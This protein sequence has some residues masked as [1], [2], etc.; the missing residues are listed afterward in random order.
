MP[1]A[2]RDYC[3]AVADANG[4]P[5]PT[6]LERSLV[7]ALRASG[8]VTAQW[9][10]VTGSVDAPLFL[11]LAADSP[12][13]RCPQCARVHL[14]ASA[15]ACTNPLCKSTGLVQSHRETDNEDY[16]AWLAGRPARRLRVEELTGQ[17]KPLPEQRRRQRQFKGA[18]LQP[19]AEH[20]LTHA[21]DILSV[22]TTMEVGIDIGSLQSVMMANMPPQRF[23]YQQRVGRAGRLGQPF[24]FA[25]TLCRD[26]THD[27]YYF[28][29]PDHITSDPPAPPYLDLGRAQIIQRV[30]AAEALRLA[31]LSLAAP[32]RPT[33]GPDS[34]HG[35]FGLAVDWP[36]RY[37]GSIVDWLTNSAEISEIVTRLTSCTPLTPA[38]QDDLV[39]WVREGLVPAIDA[40]IA[41]SS[42]IQ[43]E[44]S[45]R[46]ANAGV[47]PMFGFPSRVRALYWRAPVRLDDDEDA[48][49]AE[50]SLEIAISNFSPGA[51]ILKDK[52]VHVCA[53]FVTW[54][55]R[56]RTPAAGNP[57]GPALLIA[58]C[59]TCQSVAITTSEAPQACSVCQGTIQ[60]FKLFQPLGFRTTYLP[61][62]FDDQPERGPSLPLP[63]LAFSQQEQP[64]ERLRSLSYLVL[65]GC[66][67]YTINDNDGRLFSML[68]HQSSIVVPDPELYNEDPHLNVPDRAPDYIG[69]I[70]LVKPTDALVISLDRVDVPGPDSVIDVRT[71]AGL[72]ALWSFAEAFRRAGA[73]ELEVGPGELQ[74]G[75]QPQLVGQAVTRRIFLADSLENGAGYS[76]QLGQEKVLLRVLDR[77]VSDFARDFEAARH[78]DC[79]S[80]CPDCLRSY[81]NRHLH[82]VLEWRLALDVAELAA[83]QSLTFARWLPR[84]RLLTEDFVSAF[85]EAIPLQAVEVG[86]LPAVFAPARR[87]LAFFGHPL[88]RLEPIYYG[89][90]QVEA[91]D[92]ARETFQASETK[93]FDIYSL[94]RK[95]FDMYTWLAQAG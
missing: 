52:Q 33:P 69:A 26:R 77:L 87:R 62:D 46:L 60:P 51:E 94:G 13:W 74:V 8:V 39:H 54:D 50:R 83:G 63:Q 19:P 3:R 91:E 89:E 79:D 76:S 40:A 55:Y 68:S 20:A 27:D 34:T 35:S 32:E 93:A 64:P 7:D 45:E 88:W 61:R 28:N 70:G 58:R 95:P 25:V 4:L 86:Q 5:E 85:R 67:L 6:E 59:S 43:R 48:Q 21:V 72:S 80:S 42:Y 29:H 73:I 31:Y 38:D 1:R 37:R 44:L 15:G 49:V 14:H 84:G 10:I 2:L 12:L 75:L 47:L 9:D 57:L 65:R 53:G 81:D 71:P 90:E 78:A 30:V 17:T 23:N 24:S 82:S 41:N 11:V 66:E 18:L 92:A 36:T 22:T 56:G 16:Y